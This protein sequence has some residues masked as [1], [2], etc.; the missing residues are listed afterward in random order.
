M[1]LILA[2]GATRVY[3]Y[4]RRDTNPIPI[5]I[6]KKLVFS[7]FV[8]PKGSKEYVTK[9]YKYSTSED[10][11][12]IL[13]FIIHSN[14][15]A[16]IALSEYAQPPQFNDIPEY[17]ERFLT[18]VAKQ[19]DSVQTSNGTIY[20]GKMTRQ[21]NKQL[22]VM[23]EKGLLVFMNPN[24]EINQAQWRKLGDN[25]EIK[26]ILIN[27]FIITMHDLKTTSNL[28]WLLRDRPVPQPIGHYTH[29]LSLLATYLV[30]PMAQPSKSS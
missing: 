12:P 5:D 2:F 26:K 16:D 7:P 21:N 13:S 22:A 14:E 3:G 8:L 24:T 29:K 11:V 6:R 15:G 4:L 17:K 9:D 30:E 1:P 19:Y 23:L 27:I 10:R 20:L 28:T 25:L 18:N